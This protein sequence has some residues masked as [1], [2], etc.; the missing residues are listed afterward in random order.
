MDPAYDY[1]GDWKLVAFATCALE[2]YFGGLERR[3]ARAQGGG[4]Y[5]PENTVNIACSPGK[6]L[7]AIGDRVACA[8]TRGSFRLRASG[9]HRLGIGD[10]PGVDVG[11][12]SAA[13]DRDLRD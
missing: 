2:G 10:E 5:D 6:K 8:S 3:S 11:V 1:T 13:A 7:M 4:I 9:H 12:R